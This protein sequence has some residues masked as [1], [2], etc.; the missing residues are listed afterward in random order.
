MGFEYTHLLTIFHAIE[1][2]IKLSEILDGVIH[3]VP[4]HVLLLIS[5]NI[6][7]ELLKLLERSS[8]KV[9]VFFL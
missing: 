2:R 5:W 9:E 6:L 1:S 8:V 4:E 3:V 7:L